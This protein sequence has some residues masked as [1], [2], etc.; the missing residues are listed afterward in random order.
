MIRFYFKLSGTFPI[1]KN[2]SLERYFNIFTKKYLLQNY[3]SYKV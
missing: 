1:V 3:K 2:D